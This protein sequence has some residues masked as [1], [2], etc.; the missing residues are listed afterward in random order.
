[1]NNK[2]FQANRLLFP[3]FS[4]VVLCYLLLIYTSA[5]NGQAINDETLSPNSNYLPIIFR[6]PSLTPTSTPDPIT[7]GVLT[8]HQANDSIPYNWFS[9]VPN[10]INMGQSN[11]IWVSGLHGNLVTDDYNLITEESRNQAEWRTELAEQYKFIL[12]V[13]VIPRPST[14]YIYVVSLTWKVFLEETSY[15]YQ[16]PDYKLNAILD[17]FSYDLRGNGYIVENKIFI[18]GFSAGA[19][20]A[21]RYALL[22]PSRVKALAAGQCGGALTLPENIYGSIQMEWPIGI[23]DFNSLVGYPFNSQSYQQ[24]HQYIYIGDQD[25]NNSTLWGWGELWKSQEQVNFLINTFGASDPIRL[26]NQVSF[27]NSKGYNNIV[28]HM[29]SG[30]SHTITPQMVNDTFSFFNSFR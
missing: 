5:S 7:K 30:V 27:L 24:V 1:M 3:R 18:D 12:I 9:Y 26:Q 17:K 20:F 6:Q 14:N 19:V 15:L 25:T 29:Y 4:V 13:P 8:F 28:F 10:S 2:K 22:H 21:Q 11:Y 16:R 23:Y